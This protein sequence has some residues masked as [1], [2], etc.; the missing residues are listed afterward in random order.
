MNHPLAVAAAN[1][2]EGNQGNQRGLIS[3]SIN[4]GWASFT[5]T[6]Q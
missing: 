2:S 5:S 4:L 6:A 1:Q 3:V